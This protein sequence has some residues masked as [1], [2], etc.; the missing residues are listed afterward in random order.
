MPQWLQWLRLHLGFEI[1]FWVNPTSLVMIFPLHSDLKIKMMSVLRPL[2]GGAEDMEVLQNVLQKR[3]WLQR[4]KREWL[5]KAKRNDMWHWW[6]RSLNML[7]SS[8]LSTMIQHQALCPFSM[9]KVGMWLISAE[10]TK[11][12]NCSKN[13]LIYNDPTVTSQ[14]SLWLSWIVS[15]I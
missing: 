4:K 6:C 1:Y 2:E 7:K 13:Y 5:K 8:D 12:Q 15:C 10:T 9:I 3:E 11:F 14:V